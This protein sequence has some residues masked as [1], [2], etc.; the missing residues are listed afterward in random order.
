MKHQALY[1]IAII[2]EEPLRK[3]FSEIK[4]EFSKSYHTYHALKSP[5][6][7]TLIPPFTFSN[8][9]EQI[10]TSTLEEFARSCSVFEVSIKDYGA[11]KPKVIYLSIT[12]N[13]TLERLHQKLTD[14][15]S[16]DLGINMKKNLPF[17]PHMTLAFRD[18]S[19]QMF[20]KAWE[21]YKVES[22]RASFKAKSLFLVKHVGI[23]W[24]IAYE[25]PFAP[26][27][28]PS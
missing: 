19:P 12:K 13:D 15:C 20:H 24:D 16:K 22:F 8:Q 14:K 1:F 26:S 5:P 11:F 7:I 18:L 9:N 23:R 25:F 4:E 6:H 17:H 3:Q 2:P 21:R 27:I 28:L 10:L